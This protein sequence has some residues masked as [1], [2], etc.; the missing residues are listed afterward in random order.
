[1]RRAALAAL[2][3]SLLAGEARAADLPAG[4]S[5]EYVRA[6]FTELQKL[7]VHRDTM[8]EFLAMMFTPEQ[9]KAAEDCVSPRG[10]TAKSVR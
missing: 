2:A 8:R 3:A 4:Y 1:M 6:K 9:V 5:C 10:A 7:G